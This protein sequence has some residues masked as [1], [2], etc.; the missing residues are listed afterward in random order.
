MS[1]FGNLLSAVERSEFALQLC[2][3]SVVV[4][5]GRIVFNNK[6]IDIIDLSVLHILYRIR[7]GYATVAHTE[8]TFPIV[9]APFFK[10]IN[11]T[12]VSNMDQWTCDASPS[13]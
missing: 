9:L 3:N 11:E 2:R 6:Q 8:V 1:E 10:K 12:E 7:I 13:T 4:T 5:A